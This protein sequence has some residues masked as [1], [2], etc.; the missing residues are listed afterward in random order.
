M[1]FNAL[2]S[3][4]TPA[5]AKVFALAAV[6]FAVVAADGLSALRPAAAGALFEAADLD[7]QKFVLVASP[8][9]DGSRQ[10]L[11]IYEQ[12]SGR[13]PCF[14]MSGSN[15]AKVD[16]MLATFDFTGVCSRY[17]DAN[18]YS[19]RIG[20]TDLATS[21][22][23]SVIRKDKDI[24]LLAIPTKADAGPEY[25]V[26]RTLGDGAGFMQLVFEPGWQLKRRAFAG[27]KLGHV[28]VYRDTAAAVV[29][30]Q[31]PAARPVTRQ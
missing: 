6:A 19:L 21:Y 2:R 13:R 8:I 14:A 15:P 3:A 26:A 30:I 12:V 24:Q 18:G 16:P 1:P 31:A 29:E 4:L 25:L 27:R 23:L 11:N 10:Q 17:I 28:Y 5:K 7:Q 9:G 20:D 22:R